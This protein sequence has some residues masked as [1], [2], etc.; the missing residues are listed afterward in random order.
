MKR[1]FG[2]TGPLAACALLVAG[3]GVASAQPQTVSTAGATNVT[4]TSATLVGYL[5]PPQI[6]A[7]YAFEYGTTTN[8][9][10]TTTPQAAPAGNSLTEVTA[11]VTGLSP[12]TTYHFQLIAVIPSSTTPT[13]ETGGDKSLTT[14]GSGGG[15]GG[16]GGS[17]GH[18]SL[19]LVAR[20]LSVRNRKVSI[21]LWCVSSQSC[22]GSLSISASRMSCVSGKTFSVAADSVM[23]VKVRV[24]GGC[25]TRLNQASKHRLGA[26][27]TATLSTG[28]PKLSSRVT[29]ARG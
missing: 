20:K 8:Y 1:I 5:D 3:I 18:G 4:R 13:F 26:R 15:G 7:A 27:L 14:S 2:L 16:G 25:R 6:F 29:L 24:S 19:R 28:Q 10:H 23:T 22:N 17:S 21:P 11:M 12:G 9:G